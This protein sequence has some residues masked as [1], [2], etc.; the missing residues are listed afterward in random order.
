[1]V[2]E[3]PV[4]E[5]N[6]RRGTGREPTLRRRSRAYFTA[7]RAQATAFRTQ[8]GTRF[9][10]RSSWPR[11]GPIGWRRHSASLAYTARRGEWLAVRKELI[12]TQADVEH[13]MIEL[14]DQKMA[15]LISLG[16]WLRGLEISTA[17]I[18]LDFSPQQAKVLAQQALVA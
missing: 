1:M 16:G 13:A 10:E 7:R 6:E 11:R 8:S 2:Q 15:H 4:T 17:A 5:Q 3:E 14:R 9:D 12:A 18:E